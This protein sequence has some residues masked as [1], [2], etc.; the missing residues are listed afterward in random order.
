MPDARASIEDQGSPTSK[1]MGASGGGR[2]RTIQARSATIT[3][4]RPAITIAAPKAIF[5][6]PAS[7]VGLPRFVFGI[8]AMTGA[9]CIAPSSR[10]RRRS[11]DPSDG[12]P[13]YMCTVWVALP[14]LT[15]R[16][17]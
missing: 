10:K 12:R 8:A 13:L 5:L 11:G 4:N 6:T 15:N 2:K 14:G 16:R 3:A 7:I 1:M 9:Y 17:R